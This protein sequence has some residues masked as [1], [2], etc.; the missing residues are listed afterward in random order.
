MKVI[1][2]DFDGVLN[3][4]GIPIKKNIKAVNELFEDRDNY[5][6]VY[7]ARSR[8]IYEKTYNWL[9]KHKVKFHALVMEKMRATVYIDDKNYDRI[10]EVIRGCFTI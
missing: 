4:N 8:K 9:I 7:T 3:K 5:I 2:I 10:K 1:A 6:V